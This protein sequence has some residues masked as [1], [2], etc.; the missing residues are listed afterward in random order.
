MPE[1]E[2]ENGNE[3][4]EDV[5]SKGFV[6]RD[7]KYSELAD[8]Y[9]SG[10]VEP[11]AVLDNELWLLHQLADLE[12]GLKDKI[13]DALEKEDLWSRYLSQIYG[14]GPLLAANLISFIHPIERFKNVSKLWAYAGLSAVHW[15]SECE[16]GHKMITTS[17]PPTCKVKALDEKTHEHK[18]CGAKIVKSTYVPSPPK[19]KEGYVLL[20]NAK[21]HTT[22]WKLSDSFLKQRSDRSVYRRYYDQFRLDEER[23]NEQ[24]EK[25]LRDAVLHARAMRKV[26]KMFLQHLLIVWGEGVGMKFPDPYPVQFLGRA[27]ERPPMDRKH[28]LPERINPPQSPERLR[29]L[30]DSFYDIQ[31]RRIETYNRIV[32][33][34]YTNRD[35]VLPQ[36][37]PAA[38]A[39]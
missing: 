17:E 9:I 28:V 15:E 16:R 1:E 37:A 29:F 23:K 3:T 34:I 5:N 18:V 31:K 39:Q 19:R 33:W 35:R 38:K 26:Q 7:K 24:A 32:A 8:R 21:L 27:P 12:D 14:V 11:P 10:E 36:E 25:K 13:V 4:P 20:V 2:N 6:P 30:V 22:L